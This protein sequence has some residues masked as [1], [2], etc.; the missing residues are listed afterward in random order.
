MP[1]LHT[2]AVGPLETNC[3]LYGDDATGECAIIDPGGE[4]E[5]IAATLA[6]QSLRPTLILLTHAHFDHTGAVAALK[7]RFD[8]PVGLGE[9]EAPALS[10]ALQSG[11]TWFGFPFEPAVPDFFIADSQ[12]LAVGTAELTALATPGHSPGGLSFLGDGLV[13]VGD[14]LFRDGIGRY[15]LPGSDYEALRRSLRR[16]LSLPDT[17]RVLPGHGPATTIGRERKT[18]PYLAD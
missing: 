9:A 15:D 16:L 18:N 3:Y 14:V 6:R 10:N 5:R 13:F 1:F 7:K 2:L 17:T 4:A 11:A 12:R 8:V